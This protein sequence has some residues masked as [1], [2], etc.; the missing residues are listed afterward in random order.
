PL[1]V[2]DTNV[3][4]FIPVG[5]RN[6]TVEV[7]AMRSGRLVFQREVGLRASRVT[8]IEEIEHHFAKHVEPKRFTSRELDELQ[9]ITSWLYR[10]RERA[11]T[12]IVHDVHMIS[13]L[14]HDA[15]NGF[16]KDRVQRSIE[17]QPSEYSQLPEYDD[18][19]A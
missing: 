12:A 18:F 19:G 2:S 11:H 8:V 17:A 16:D 15:F 3:L 7:Y 10:R 9:I 14:I 4:I 6:A 1:A 13:D 5:E